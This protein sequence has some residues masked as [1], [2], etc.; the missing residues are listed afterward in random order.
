LQGER[1]VPQEKSLGRVYVSIVVRQESRLEGH[2]APWPFKPRLLLIIERPL[3]KSFEAVRLK[4]FL[5]LLILWSREK[6][7][8]SLGSVTTMSFD[9]LTADSVSVVGSRWLD[10]TQWQRLTWIR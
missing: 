3:R 1:K 9:G 7:R 10:W 5:E 2:I 4:S 6:W 8:S